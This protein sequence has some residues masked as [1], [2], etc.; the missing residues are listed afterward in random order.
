MKNIANKVVA[1]VLLIL[2]FIIGYISSDV[3]IL[4]LL[5]AIAVT[6]IFSKENYIK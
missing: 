1:V 5:M 3:T 6:L 2:G 4:L